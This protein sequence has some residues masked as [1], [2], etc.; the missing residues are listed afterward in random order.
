MKALPMLRIRGMSGPTLDKSL[1][2]PIHTVGNS[3]QPTTIQWYP[4]ADVDDREQGE[5]WTIFLKHDVVG[6][7]T[8]TFAIDTGALPTGITLNAD[9][10]FSGTITDA[11]G[12]GSVTFTA[13]N[14]DGDF[15]SGTLSWTIFEP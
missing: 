12:T 3:I 2:G 11:S 10:T 9:G 13:S 7:A 6:V 4:I 8:I 1:R 5:T 15:D 14:A